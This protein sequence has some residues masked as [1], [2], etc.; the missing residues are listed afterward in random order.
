MPLIIP[1]MMIIFQALYL[2]LGNTVD[3]IQE[4]KCQDELKS[5]YELIKSNGGTINKSVTI[6]RKSLKTS[7]IPL[8]YFEPDL[9]K[10]MIKL[11]RLLRVS[12]ECRL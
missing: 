4:F 10:K 9:R 2:A 7:M 5:F 3:F 11:V 8:Q 12:V 6:N 1:K